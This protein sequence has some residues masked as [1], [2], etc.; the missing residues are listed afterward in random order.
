M[1]MKALRP[2]Q[3]AACN[4]F[5]DH[6]CEGGTAGLID[7]ATGL[8]KSHVIATVCKEVIAEYRKTRILMAVHNRELVRQNFQELIQLWPQAPAG[9]NS[10]GLNRRDWQSQIIFGSIQSIY[11]HTDILGKFDLVVIDEAHLLPKKAHGMYQGLLA[12]LRNG[13]P[14]MRVLGLTATPFRLDSGRL[15]SG[16]G[17]LFEKTVYSYGIGPGIADGYLSP[18]IT[19]AMTAEIDTSKVHHSRGDFIS[20]EL[21]TAA[22]GGDNV[23]GA[24]DEIIQYGAD[25]RAWIVFCVGLKH[26]KLVHAELIRRGIKSAIVASDPKVMPPDERDKRIAAFSRGYV[27]AMV[28]VSMLTTGF[29]VPH[30]DLIALLRPTESPGL[31]IQMIGRGTR[32]ANGKENCLVLDF[33]RILKTHGPIDKME[34]IEREKRGKGDKT[35]PAIRIRICPECNAMMP[36]TARV[37]DAC[38]SAFPAQERIA[39]HDAQADGE[40]VIL[41]TQIKPRWV[42]VTAWRISKGK[43][44]EAG[45]EYLRIA[46]LCGAFGTVNEFLLFDHGGF[47]PKTAARRWLELTGVREQFTPQT[48]AEALERKAELLMQAAIQITKEGKYYKVMRSTPRK[49]MG[50]E[51]AA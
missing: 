13:K 23:N 34:P 30:I 51:I 35:D 40:N 4:A 21:E 7:L 22:I 48:T 5:Y 39:Q 49:E 36:L 28:N 50:N 10:A 15:D 3:R 20:S 1:A 47:H 2:Y 18:L 26:A 24:V 25:R 14:K 9:I 44:G 31:A 19:K 29:N 41:S 16:E 6:I 46:Y 38:G 11:K 33:G 43:K 45:P 17:A 37:C 8:G 42:D 27:R 12:N 32:L